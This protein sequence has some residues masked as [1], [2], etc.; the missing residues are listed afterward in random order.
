MMA[1]S[2]GVRL[3]GVFSFAFILY[4]ALQSGLLWGLAE[5]G[6]VEFYQVSLVTSGA[7]L[8]VLN[9]DGGRGRW[10]IALLQGLLIGWATWLKPQAGVLLLAGLLSYGSYVGTRREQLRLAMGFV[11]GVLITIGINVGYLVAVGS[12]PEFASLLLDHLPAYVASSTN[13][14][15]A[16][17]MRF[18]SIVLLS[19]LWLLLT[20]FGLAGLELYRR[21]CGTPGGVVLI[22]VL[23]AW[24]LL[25]FLS[26]GYGFYYHAVAFLP[27]YSYAVSL[28]LVLLVDRRLAGVFGSTDGGQCPHFG[29]RGG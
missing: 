15:E 10:A 9:R 7:A 16:I 14:M 29:A 24:G 27:A 11:A 17:F 26:S 20:V 22:V 23:G 13:S 28:A 19:P 25:S 8:Y 2:A 1:R 12:I 3:R 4:C 21:S 18:A 5:R 6:Q